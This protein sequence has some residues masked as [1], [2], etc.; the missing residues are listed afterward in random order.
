MSTNPRRGGV[1]MHVTSLPGPESVGTLGDGAMMFID[2]LKEAGM[3]VWQVLPVSPTGFGESPYQSACAL[4][5]NPLMID[6]NTLKREGYLP[7]DFALPEARFPAMIDF[8]RV[9]PEKEAVLRQAFAFSREKMQ[10]EGAFEA[11]EKEH[12]W[13]H[14]YAV[15]MACKMHF[16]QRSWMEWP[17]QDL[18]LRKKAALEKYEEML[19]DDI[20]YYEFLQI[21]FRKQWMAVKK[22]AN[23]NGVSILGDMPIYVAGD[24]SDVWANAEFFQLDRER[25]P[26]SV[27]GVPPDYFSEDGQLWGNPL[28]RWQKLK[29]NGYSFWIARLRGMGELFDSVRIDHF[30]GFA[31]YYTIPAGEKTARNGKWVIGPGAD[32]F[33]VVKEQCPEVNVVAEDLGA[34]NERVKSLL[35]FCG[36]PGMKVLQFAFDGDESE[37]LNALPSFHRNCVAYTGTHD[38]DTSLGWWYT[39]SLESRMNACRRMGE[40]DDNNVVRRMIETVFMS[41]CDTAVA[42]IQDFL[43]LPSEYRMNLPGTV[44]GTNWR[45]RCDGSKL[46]HEL[47]AWMH[48]LNEKANRL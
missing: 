14:D 36:Y 3:R 7:A 44:G 24:S 21:M 5:G 34:V 25:H 9:I 17:D 30:I 26:T 39:A 41:V 46:S 8:G 1:L 2:F 27:A 6:L 48:A 16:Q 22:Y 10:A 38:N 45:Y 20:L 15:F 23:A 32:F 11:A 47:A 42:P 18:R 40:L 19:A 28:Y 31:N 43:S 13:L 33:K 4:A 35:A 37:N 29:N 12:Y